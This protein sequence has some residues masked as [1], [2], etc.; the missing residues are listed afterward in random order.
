MLFIHD[1][2]REEM[3]LEA[4]TGFPDEICGF[5]FGEEEG[6]RHITFIRSVANA[7]E[8]A[9]GRNFEI[10]A[11]DYLDAERFAAS[12]GLQLLGVYH[13]HPDHPA[14]PS[15]TDRLAAQP[16]FSYIILAVHKNAFSDLRSWRLNEQDQFEEETVI[17]TTIV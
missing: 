5:L 10:S 6:D 17:E 8:G 1:K 9:R 11:K 3:I 4:V 13:S 7:K 16:F 14:I 15:E 12:S 2:A